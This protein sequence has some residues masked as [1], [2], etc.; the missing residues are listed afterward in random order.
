MIRFRDYINEELDS[1]ES[2]V[3]Y[4][5]KHCTEILKVYEY[6]DKYL[7]RGAPSDEAVYKSQSRENRTPKDSLKPMQKM[8]DDELVKLG[9]KALRGNSI[10]VTTDPKIANSYTRDSVYIIFPEDGFNFTYLDGRKDDL[11]LSYHSKLPLEN[12]I[13]N[14]DWYDE[15][16][17]KYENDDTEKQYQWIENLRN[18]NFDQFANILYFDVEG[19][20][21]DVKTDLVK[22]IPISMN[23]T[24]SGK[25]R[26]I[27]DAIYTAGIF[28]VNSNKFETMY[29]PTNINLISALEQNVYE[30]YI[31]GKYVAIQIGYFRNWIEDKIYD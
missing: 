20:L 24:V 21:E 6:S 31:Q 15:L 12:N 22:N 4:L 28:K 16:L 29:N 7:Y 23:T 5:K 1:P 17:D 2:I 10:F 8:F 9:M 18:F 14:L 3:D 19:Y 11:V 30:I 27:N 26:A 13:V 25:S